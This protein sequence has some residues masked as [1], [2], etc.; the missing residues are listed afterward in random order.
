MFK[1][2]LSL[3]AIHYLLKGNEQVSFDNDTKTMFQEVFYGSSDYN[4]FRDLYYSFVQDEIFKLFPEIPMILEATPHMGY[5]QKECFVYEPIPQLPRGKNILLDGYF[6]AKEYVSETMR[7]SW[8][9]IQDSLGLLKKWNLET[10]EQRNKTVFV[11][12]RLGDFKH[13]ANHFVNLRMYFLR[14]MATFTL[15]T[16]FLVFSEEPEY[17][18]SCS[19][20]DE[21]CIFVQESDELN[22]LFLMSNCHRGAVTANSTFSWWGAFFARQSCGSPDKF[23]ACMPSQWMVTHNTPTD[24]VY[25]SWATIVA[26]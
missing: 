19:H 9:C 17:A 5:K 6:Q 16:K 25:P 26:V 7:P 1:F 18:K 8:N 2:N 11:H 22:T 12:V 15:D 23:V 14:A 3:E 10:Q 21:R 24:G 13:H 20:F 4:T